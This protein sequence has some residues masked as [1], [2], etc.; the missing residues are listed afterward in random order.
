ML[1]WL[2]I[3]HSCYRCPFV[4]IALS[5]VVYSVFF[6][7][8]F[9]RE[10]AGESRDV[11]LLSWLCTSDKRSRCTVGR[12]LRSSCSRWI[13]AI[14]RLIQLPA[15]E[16]CDYFFFLVEI[17]NFGRIIFPRTSSQNSSVA[18]RAPGLGEF[19]RWDRSIHTYTHTHAHTH[20]HTH[21]IWL[22]WTFTPFIVV[23]LYIFTV[24]VFFV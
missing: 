5:S 18:Q 2:L 15:V 23:P 19:H 12:E 9:A 8:E 21:T 24:C 3:N 20:T 16:D 6:S 17:T 11:I 1:I 13:I 14:D 10:V 4:C 22:L 7:R